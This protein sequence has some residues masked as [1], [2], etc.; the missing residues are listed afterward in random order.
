MLCSNVPRN[1][2][3]VCQAICRQI[4]HLESKCENACF[5]HGRYETDAKELDRTHKGTFLN[6][7]ES[8]LY[9][10]R[11]DKNTWHFL[12]RKL[13]T[14]VI[15]ERAQ[16][17]LSAAGV[18]SVLR[19]FRLQQIARFNLVRAPRLTINTWRIHSVVNVA[20]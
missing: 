5:L 11:V 13:P 15:F 7:F 6:I 4:L 12:P 18:R 19:K 17:A 20:M 9:W 8:Y 1:W 10:S 16:A 3:T 2:V 14:G